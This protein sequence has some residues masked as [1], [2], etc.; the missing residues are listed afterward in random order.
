[1]P[2]RLRHSEDTP[3]HDRRCDLV[4]RMIYRSITAISQTISTQPRIASNLRLTSQ[5]ARRQS[6]GS[7]MTNL[8]ALLAGTKALLGLAA[9]AI[10]IASLTLGI[11][12]LLPDDHHP[13][14]TILR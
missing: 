2:G 14:I 10:A 9:V 5:N 4:T 1:M 3:F 13:R 12:A 8:R 11:G 7:P 6:R